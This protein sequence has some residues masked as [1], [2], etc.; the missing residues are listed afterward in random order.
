MKWVYP[1]RNRKK[2]KA[3]K[4]VENIFIL[5][6]FHVQLNAPAFHKVWWTQARLCPAIRFNRCLVLVSQ[7]RARHGSPPSLAGRGWK[8]TERMAVL[9]LLF[10]RLTWCLS[11]S[12]WAYSEQRKALHPHYSSQKLVL[13]GL[14][15]MFD[16][17]CC[18]LWKNNLQ[19]IA[20]RSIELICRL[21][22]S[23]V[24][25]WMPAT[26]CSAIVAWP[27]FT[28]VP[29]SGGTACR[30]RL[31][32]LLAVCT[33]MYVSHVALRLSGQRAAKPWLNHLFLYRPLTAHLNMSEEGVSWALNNF[34]PLAKLSH[35]KVFR[36]SVRVL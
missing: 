35:Q 21:L 12:S 29:F 9:T 13:I 11:K 36:L 4:T 25:H 6:F 23:S 17:A 7:K 24:N 34:C 30:M 26:A 31:I 32:R 28:W 19:W 3:S 18:P 15:Y 20:F 10:Q 14:I 5:S 8:V 1:Y 33:D 27:P 22:T 16:P 2:C